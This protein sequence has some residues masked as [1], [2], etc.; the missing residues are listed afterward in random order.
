MKGGVNRET[1]Y[2]TSNRAFVHRR[3]LGSLWLG[4]DHY[5]SLRYENPGDRL[6]GREPRR[7]KSRA[8]RHPS[9]SSRGQRGTVTLQVPAGQWTDPIGLASSPNRAVIAVIGT[10]A[11][12]A[13]SRRAFRAQGLRRSDCGGAGRARATRFR[14]GV[15]TR[16]SILRAFVACD[17]R[18]GSRG[19]EKRIQFRGG[20]ADGLAAGRGTQ[21]KR[22]SGI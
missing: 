6:G 3:L 22:S 19:V 5:T 9:H 4:R 1:F 10:E 21:R 12:I 17:C 18:H 16:H 13:G 20:E 11:R 14:K 2:R 7:W 8:A 15:P